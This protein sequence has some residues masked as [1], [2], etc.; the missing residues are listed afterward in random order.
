MYLRT[1]ALSFVIIIYPKKAES[2][3]VTLEKIHYSLPSYTLTIYIVINYFKVGSFRGS[4]Q[5]PNFYNSWIVSFE[6]DK[7]FQTFRGN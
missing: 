2:D 5:L 6:T 1:R 3:R 7:D 4:V